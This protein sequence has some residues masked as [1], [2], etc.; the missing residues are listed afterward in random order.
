MISAD[1]PVCGRQATKSWMAPPVQ[2]RLRRNTAHDGKI[3]RLRSPEVEFRLPRR[4]QTTFSDPSYPGSGTAA[5]NAMC[6]LTGSRYRTPEVQKTSTPRSPRIRIRDDR[7]QTR[8][9]P[10]DEA[11]WNFQQVPLR[12]SR[13][14]SELKRGS[15]IL[16][17]STS[18][19]V[20]RVHGRRP[21]PSARP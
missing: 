8:L 5:Y 17:W 4:R 9:T 10:S 19:D 13:S 3:R 18:A 11:R 1:G 2:T 20:D 21:A 16:E 14:K 7:R 6:E 15:S 12:G